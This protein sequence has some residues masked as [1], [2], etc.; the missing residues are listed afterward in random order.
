[1][2]RA[3]YRAWAALRAR[4]LLRRM[5]ELE[6]SQ[7]LSRDE[8]EALQ[9]GR[10]RDTLTHAAREVPYYADLFRQAGLDPAAVKSVADLRSLPALSR[11]TLAASYDRLRCRDGARAGV[12]ERSTGGSSGRPVRFLVD[13]KEMTER[14]AHIYRN[15]RWLGWDL[16]DRMAYVWGSDIDSSE[17]SGWRGGLRDAVAGVLWLDAFRLEE[18]TLDHQLDRLERFD[19]AVVIGYPSSL[20]LLARRALATGRRGPLRGIE[21]SAEMLAPEV[22]RELE[23]VF[24][25]AVL[26]RY[27]CREAGVIAHECPAGGRHVNAEAV[28]MEMEQ[29]EV[30]VT[31]LNN[32]VMPLI[33]YRLEDAAEP[34]PGACP[35]GRGLPL[36]GALRGRVSD[37]IRSPSGRL[38]HG[39]FFTHLFYGAQGVSAFQVEQTARN[40]LEIRYVADGRFDARSRDVI[41]TAIRSHGDAAFS[42][43]WVPVK[44]IDPGPSGKFRFTIGWSPSDRPDSRNSPPF[45]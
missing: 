37:I 36:V 38:I 32:R 33:R 14:S 2:R 10:L 29:G 19:P 4:P 1:M 6:R 30:L 12:I 35:C 43:G 41:T 23:Q 27:G 42:V 16:G 17:H 5:Q 9:I 31:T 40:T 28:V 13:E 45:Q 25:C 8:I 3:I 34:A 26:D 20:H 21:T 18:A 11:E 39:E 22:R 7:W 15:L 44:S 24:G